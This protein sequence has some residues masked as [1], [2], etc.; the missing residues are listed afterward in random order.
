[1]AD[2]EIE[3]LQSLLLQLDQLDEIF[4]KAKNPITDIPEE[5]RWYKT[6]GDSDS[7]G[8]WLLPAELLGLDI[9]HTQKIKVQRTIVGE[10]RVLIHEIL[11]KEG[12]DFSHYLSNDELERLKENVRWAKKFGLSN[13]QCAEVLGEKTEAIKSILKKK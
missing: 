7:H 5:E 3:Q 9:A 2:K 13:S 8:N 12:S 6:I 1:M 11:E 4:W 10:I